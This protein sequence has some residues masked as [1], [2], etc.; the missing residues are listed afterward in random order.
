L[1]NTT[2]ANNGRRLAYVH[3]KKS[4]STIGVMFCGG[5]KSDMQGQKALMLETFCKSANIA[6]TRFDYSGHG[7]SDG[8]FTEGDIGSWLDDALCIFDNIAAK[9]SEQIIVIGSSMGA[10]IAT[11][12]ATKRVKNV[13]G[14]ITIAAAP[15]FT[16]KLLLPALNA[17]QRNT[18]NSGGTI[19]L[20][21][22]YDDGSPYPISA[23]LLTNSRPH[24]ILNA[25]VN[26]NAPVRLLHGTK[27]ADV[28]YTLSIELMNAITSNDV[29]LNLIK[30]AD[31]RLSSPV[32][33]KTT[34]DTLQSMLERINKS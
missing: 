6:Y 12:L 31:H 18:L 25:P 21:S 23:N 33:L 4:N 13:A 29:A 8:E 19:N 30:N 26:I 24:C 3:S 17:D 32:N 20:P 7:S 14:L 1:T 34:I 10:W 15:D 22:D 9:T 28:P 27:D 16:E 11:L 2:I 5:F